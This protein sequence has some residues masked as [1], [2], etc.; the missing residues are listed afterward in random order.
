[1]PPRHRLKKTD[2][3]T[4]ENLAKTRREGPKQ[5]IKTGRQ[6]KDKRGYLLPSIAPPGQIILQVYQTNQKT[7]KWSVTGNLAREATKTHTRPTRQRY[8]STKTDDECVQR[9]KTGTRQHNNNN[10]GKD[11]D[12]MGN[13][14][15]KKKKK[16][17]VA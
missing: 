11:T 13:P 7:G 8:D 3:Q 15:K 12:T 4:N 10:K 2:K 6:D 9:H 17:G 16:T 1:L 14:P 5:N